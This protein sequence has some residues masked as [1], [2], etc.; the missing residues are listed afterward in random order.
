MIVDTLVDGVGAKGRRVGPY[1][2]M[3]NW[4]DQDKENTWNREPEL[5]SFPSSVIAWAT[6]KWGFSQEGF[7]AC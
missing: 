5:N 6:K 3:T 7:N 4:P 1:P 2:F